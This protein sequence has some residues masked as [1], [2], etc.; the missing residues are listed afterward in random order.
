MYSTSFCGSDDVFDKRFRPVYLFDKRFG[1]FFVRE[2]PYHSAGEHDTDL[3]AG[4]LLTG[5]IPML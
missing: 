4:A 5:P 3:T 1:A 2:H